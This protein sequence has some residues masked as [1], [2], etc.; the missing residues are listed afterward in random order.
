MTTTNEWSTTGR[1][2]SRIARRFWGGI[3]Q[4]IVDSGA[5]DGTLYKPGQTADEQ[6]RLS[7]YDRRWA[8]YLNDEL[9]G[10]LYRAG[11]YETDMPVEFNPVP[12]VIAFYVANTLNGQ[13]EVQATQEGANSEGLAAAVE[14]VW[15]WSNFPAL[16][17]ALTRTAAVLGDVFLKVAE[18]RP[19]AGEG[20]TGVYLQDIAPSVV[21]WW[22]ADE[23]DFLTAIR[24]DT[25]RL[26]SVFTG[27]ER[28]HTL[29]EVWRKRW[30]DGFAGAR[31]YEISAGRLLVDSEATGAVA[32]LAFEELG[33]DFV[34]IVWARTDTP[35][36][37]QTAQIDRY[38]TLAW[39][40]G[41]LNRPLGSVNANARA[42]DGRPLAVPQGTPA[43][44]EAV[45]TE[46][47]DG[48]MGVLE[49]P[50]ATTFNWAGNPI[51]FGAH[52]ARMEAIER[53]VVNSLPEYRVATIDASTQIAT[54]TMELLLSHAGQ[55]VLDLRDDLERALV[56][57][58]MMAL[59]IAQVAGVAPAVFGAEVIGTF[60]DGG[61]EHVFVVRPVFSKSAASRAAEVGALTQAGA[62]IEGAAEVAGYNERQVEALANRAIATF[63][64][65]ERG[66]PGGPRVE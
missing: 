62:T 40:A 15:R 21:R 60:E 39:Q 29:V 49:L 20:P 43:G 9:Y 6:A 22:D 31:Y 16:R 52:N 44:L 19:E 55:R 65:E 12:M 46:V 57:A 53:G 7:E 26:T 1:P 32:E 8:Y 11:L 4:R 33:Y 2:M 48:V 42:A 13:L 45:Y 17:R 59:S 61:T 50:G 63:P 3:G 56:R 36:R 30:A 23:R 27:E 35:W 38:N 41:R 5:L 64:E 51:D 18:R 47:G 66:A 58:Q 24:I 14:Q 10:R 28:R 37:H 25:P 34:P 54:E